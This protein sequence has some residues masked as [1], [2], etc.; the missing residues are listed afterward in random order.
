MTEQQQ[1]ESYYPIKKRQPVSRFASAQDETVWLLRSIR[2]TMFFFVALAI[3]LIVGGIVGFV[4]LIH[5]V[6]TTGPAGL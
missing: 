2:A 3:L 4:E 5:A 1:P 6:N